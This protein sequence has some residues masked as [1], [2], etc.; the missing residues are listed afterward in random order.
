[1][2]TYWLFCNF[3]VSRFITCPIPSCCFL[4][5]KGNTVQVLGLRVICSHSFISL[6]FIVYRRQYFSKMAA[7]TSIIQY[8]LTLLY[9]RRKWQPTPAFLP[10]EF[11]GQRNLA[12]YNSPQGCKMLDTAEQQ[13]H[14]HI[15]IWIWQHLLQ[16]VKAVSSLLESGLAFFT[17][18]LSRLW[19]TCC[20][21]LELRHKELYH[22]HL[23]GWNTLEAC[24]HNVST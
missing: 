23:A 20:Y 8:I 2:H 10:G 19:Q 24:S 13:T 14:T 15:T 9:W 1:M 4:T 18:F 7:T 16:K 3:S 12:D 11:H 5:H 22:I 21:L 17:E 6:R